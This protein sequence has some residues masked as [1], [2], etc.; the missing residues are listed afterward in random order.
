MSVEG[1]IGTLMKTTIQIWIILILET[2]KNHKKQ[3]SEIFTSLKKNKKLKLKRQ[4]MM[5]ISFQANRIRERKLTALDTAHLKA[6][7]FHN[8]KQAQIQA[9]I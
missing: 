4:V 7:L 8:M 5:K 2:P 6:K 1:K 9:Q 3:V